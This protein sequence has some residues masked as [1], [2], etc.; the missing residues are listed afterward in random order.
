MTT[1]ALFTDA[2]D[3]LGGRLTEA[4]TFADAVGLLASLQAV[5]VKNGLLVQPV[6]IRNGE[7]ASLQHRSAVTG[8]IVTISVQPFAE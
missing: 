2:V 3:D 5:A 6:E 7:G 1:F 8:E 4:Q